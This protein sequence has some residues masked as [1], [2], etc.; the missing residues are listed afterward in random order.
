[1][2]KETWII[3]KEFEKSID[4][5]PDKIKTRIL[6]LKSNS[7]NKTFSGMVSHHC[8][9]SELAYG[10][11]RPHAYGNNISEIEREL[12]DYIKTFTSIGVE[13]NEFFDQLEY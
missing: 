5:Y 9:P 1:M 6:Q 7:S 4:G 3:I 8:K 10:V 2:A 12:L 11:M 13:E